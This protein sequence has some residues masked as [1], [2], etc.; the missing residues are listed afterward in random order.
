MI[1]CRGP[2]THCCPPYLSLRQSHTADFNA[3]ITQN[4]AIQM[5]Q[6]EVPL[7]L[8]GASCKRNRWRK[9]RAATAAGMPP[10]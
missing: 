8:N 2:L 6:L 5:A 4:T 1:D 3:P 7:T 10:K 9:R